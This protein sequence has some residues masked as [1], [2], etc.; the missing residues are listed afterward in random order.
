MGAGRPTALTPEVKRII[1]SA[2]ES[3][4]FVSNACQIAGV[5]E[6]SFYNWI[7]RGQ[8]EDPADGEYREFLQSCEKT[9]AMTEA[10]AVASIRSA[11][12]RNWKACAWF[13]S[14]RHPRRW[15]RDSAGR[16]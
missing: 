1:L 9:I 3:G 15:G 16:R 8:S 7:K 11:G 6:K 14:R 5:A 13:L 10:S 2:L 12:R 4:V